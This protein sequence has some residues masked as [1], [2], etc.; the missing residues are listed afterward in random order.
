MRPKIQSKSRK[1]KTQRFI[2]FLFSQGISVIHSFF[3]GNVR[4]IQGVTF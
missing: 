1:I 4:I 2:E 3:P